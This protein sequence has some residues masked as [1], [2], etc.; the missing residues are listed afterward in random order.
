MY[1]YVKIYTFSEVDGDMPLIRMIRSSGKSIVLTIP[2]QL[3]EAY[4][5]DDG[6]P[7]EIIP[8]GRGELK[9]R[10]ARSGGVR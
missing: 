6:D 8:L 4:D 5:I 2:S 10:K 3:V 9:I 1:I 7:M